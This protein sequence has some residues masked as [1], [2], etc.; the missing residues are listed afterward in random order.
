MVQPLGGAREAPDA[1]QQANPEGHIPFA[2]RVGVT[3]HRQITDTPELNASI[4]DALLRIAALA[5]SAPEVPAIIVAV[6]SLAEGAD[7]L[8]AK[9]V[10]ADGRNRL[11]V[12]LP[13]IPDDYVEDFRSEV[14]RREFHEL[15]RSA[16]DVWQAPPEDEREAAY[17]TAGHHVADRCD[18]LI[19]LW[20]GKPSRGRGGTA[21]TVAYARKRG[22]PVVW[23]RPWS[24]PVVTYEL[25]TSSTAVIADAAQDLRRFNA[26]KVPASSI[27][28]SVAAEW[29]SLGLEAQPG[30]AA[31]LDGMRATAARAALRLLPCF[32]RA[33]V[34]AVRYQ[35]RF[36]R[37][38]AA[39]FAAASGAVVVGA[40]QWNYLLDR[41]ILAFEMALLALLLA[42]LFLSRRSRLH[43]RWI[44]YRFLAERLRS[45]YF[46]SLASTSDRGRRSSRPAYL[47]DADDLWIARALEE[48]TARMPHASLR[49]A[50]IRSLREYLATVWIA[51]QIT[52]HVKASRIHRRN[53]EV[54]VA[55]TAC[56]FA[57]TFVAA[58]IHVVLQE[59][60]SWLERLLIMVSVC[61][62]VVGA[63][64]HG[65]GTM[66]QFR[67]NADRYGRM[68]LLLERLR[69]EMRR[70]RSVETVRRI[71]V[72]AERVMREENS[73]WFGVMRFF[74]VELIT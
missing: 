66:R 23:V 5:P 56:L 71:A 45:A 60:P 25:E 58:F 22:R 17:E 42:I 16:C 9:Q 55:A 32:A 41:W 18:V 52:Y 49:P 11:E 19:A 37:V 67:R 31:G 73:D 10:L 27:R 24:P 3:G 65:F 34:L 53:D 6:S 35:R 62:P 70:A 8:V 29:R 21:E 47:S 14:S 57:L 61:V 30:G 54:L 7:R 46:L 68:T 72:D 74:D 39:M 12:A 51:G 15:L 59:G 1:A 36:Q 38:S 26:A 44:S 33:D 40:L 64:L 63:A 13:M 50:D 48:A 28:A 20:D 2:I 43:E 4:A 69:E